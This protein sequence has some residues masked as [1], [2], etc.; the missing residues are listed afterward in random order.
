MYSDEFL[1]VQQENYLQDDDKNKK[2]YYFQFEIL[3]GLK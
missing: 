1:K 2:M 3:L